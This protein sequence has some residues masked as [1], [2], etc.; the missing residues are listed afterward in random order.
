METTLG[1]PTPPDAHIEHGVALF[2]PSEFEGGALAAGRPFQEALPFGGRA[3][4]LAALVDFASARGPARVAVLPGRSGSGKTSLLSAL[5]DALAAQRVGTM[6]RFAT[7]ITSAPTPTRLPPGPC[8]IVIDDAG[9]KAAPA[10]LLPMA[11]DRRDVRFVL[12]TRPAGLPRLSALLAQV[13][14]SSDLV[15]I[16]PEL[17]ALSPS[18]AEAAAQ[19]VLGDAPGEF[20]AALAKH[21]EGHPFVIALAGRLVREEAIHPVLLGKGELAACALDRGHEL[22]LLRSSAAGDPKLLAGVLALVALLAPVRTS[23]ER[24]LQGAGDLLGCR[25]RDL[26]SALRALEAA[27]VVDRGPHGAR[28]VPGALSDH[29]L[30]R[31]LVGPLTAG[32]LAGS[33]DD[34]VRALEERFGAHAIVPL[35]RNAGELDGPSLPSGASDEITTALFRH[36]RAGIDAASAAD[37]CRLLAGLRELSSDH[38]AAM[39]DLAAAVLRSPAQTEAARGPSALFSAVSVLYELPAILR[40]VGLHLA[41]LPRAADLLWELG[42]DDLRLQSPHPDHPMR[43]LR[44][45]ASRSSARPA[46][47]HES[48]LD[49]VDRWLVADDAHDHKHSPLDV[50]DTFL[51]EGA[52]FAGPSDERRRAL[53]KQALAALSG[54]AQSPKRRAALSGVN[55]LERVLSDGSGGSSLGERMEPGWRDEERLE[56]LAM[57]GAAASNS[58]DPLVHFAVADALRRAARRA[59]S[60]DV[61]AAAETALGNVP[62]STERRLY[63]ALT[64]RSPAQRG[65]IDMPPSEIPGSGEIDRGTERRSADACRAVV[66]EML[67]EG[68][69]PAQTAEGLGAALEAL[70]LAGKSGSPRLL[71]HVLSRKHPAAAVTI[72]EA[73]MGAPESPLGPHVASLL[74][75]LR[76]ASPERAEALVGSIVGGGN[77][78]LCASLAQVFHRW[79]EKPLPG[80]R[81]ALRHLLGHRDGFVRR[82]AL[83]AL[84]TLAKSSPRDAVELAVGVDL[85]EGPEVAEALFGALD[86]GG[87][88]SEGALSEEEIIL[89]LTR[90]GAARSLDGHSTMRFLHHAGKRMPEDVT[91]LFIERIARAASGIVAGAEEYEPLPPEGLSAILTGLARSPEW[92]PLLRRV[93][94]LARA[95]I[96]WVRFHAARLFHD[97]SRSFALPTVEVLSEWVQDGGESELEAI[98]ALLEEAPPTFLFAHLELVATLLRRAHTTGEGCFERVRSALFSV[99][100]GQARPRS[101]ARAERSETLLRS[102]AREAAARLPPKSPEQKFFESVAK[103]AEALLAEEDAGQDDELFDL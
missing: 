16:L 27:G 81:E 99:V 23:D 80:D 92:L 36:V 67:A 56:I 61:R 85:S 37:R 29:A 21:A 14:L 30:Y 47:V 9:R 90:L 43:V 19:H 66:D 39:L 58:G 7:D 76:E 57:L 26:V 33:L 102:Q 4:I 42:R 51:S 48:L 84:R 73:V 35:I 46:G 55:G 40:R 34:R 32:S 2:G 101:G 96:G 59:S 69:A 6:L 87:L 54:C 62:T 88:F 70:A 18:E 49:A 5:A 25:R 38:P 86:A 52:A 78:T 45:L 94:H 17:G 72:C 50:I 12:T 64:Q 82:A 75:A 77:A 68:R 41:H 71:L 20:A 100:T 24:F 15:R 11:I 79:V 89:F 13:G 91:G 63:E 28:V 103:H 93:R 60:P 44:E 83:G 22:L 31:A 65:L 1:F 97:A 53:R 95:R 8:L 74:H 10:M 98:S 3:E